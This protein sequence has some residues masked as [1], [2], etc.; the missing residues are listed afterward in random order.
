MEAVL[1][2]LWTIQTTVFD[3]SNVCRIRLG[4]VLGAESKLSRL[5][6]T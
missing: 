6:D 5:I 3:E 4:V 2:E 1:N